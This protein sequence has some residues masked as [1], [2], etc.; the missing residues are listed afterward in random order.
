MPARAQDA[1][2]G[3]WHDLVERRPAPG[4][5]RGGYSVPN[6]CIPFKV[7]TRSSGF[8]PPNFC[9]IHGRGTG[10]SSCFFV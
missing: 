1:G 10:S 5:Q 2:E 6:P 8:G 4:E 7:G 3:A 9:L